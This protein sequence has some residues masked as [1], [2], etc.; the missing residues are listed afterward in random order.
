MALVTP[1]LPFSHCVGLAWAHLSMPTV[2]KHCAPFRLGII[3]H[4]T[5]SR[6]GLGK[7][8]LPLEGRSISGCPLLCFSG[9]YERHHTHHTFER[10]SISRHFTPCTG[11]DSLPFDSEW[12]CG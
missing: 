1:P 11:L 2:P 6:P 5:Y 3:T 12:T 4:Q 8:R 9:H 7:T 10:S